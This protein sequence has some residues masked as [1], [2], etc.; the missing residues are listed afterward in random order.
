MARAAILVLVAAA[1]IA[2]CTAQE[3]PGVLLATF[4]NAAGTTWSWDAVNDPVMG[5]ES[6]SKFSLNQTARTIVWNGIVRIVPS[7]KAPGFCNLETTNAVTTRANDASPFTHILI[8]ARTS[9]PEYAGFKFSFAADT[10]NRQFKSFKGVFN[11]TTTAWTTVA[12]PFNQ[13]SNDWSPY[14]GDC[15][16]KDP[17]GLQHKCC[18]PQTPEVC[19]TKKN[20]HD[21]SELGIWTE[22]AAGTFNLE[23]LWIG[24]GNVTGANSESAVTYVDIPTLSSPSSASRAKQQEKAAQQ[25]NPHQSYC[26]KPIQSHLKYNVSGRLAQNYLPFG[27]YLPLESLAFAVCCDSMFQAFAEPQNFYSRPDV[28]L[29]ANMNQDGPTTFYDSAC[30]LPVFVAPVNRTFADFQADTKEHEWPSFRHDE[31][32]RENVFINTTTGDV[33]SKCGTHL[34]TYTPDDKGDRYCVDLVC[35]SGSPAQRGGLVLM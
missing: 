8:R 18:T 15:F 17:T 10:L 2:V 33:S 1:V 29:F 32:I 7:L 35:I 14:T 24:A 31:I 34:G 28:Q 11:L 3:Q 26:S 25:A 21:I 30:G 9:T 12:I 22:G 20:L 4:D 13:F 27:D 19:P 6:T 16:T 23:V 5:G